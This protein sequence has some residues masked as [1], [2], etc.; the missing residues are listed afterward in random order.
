MLTII[1]KTLSLIN[2]IM[3]I[4]HV[5]FVLLHINIYPYEYHYKLF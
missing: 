5:I 2:I 3:K 1:R 4:N